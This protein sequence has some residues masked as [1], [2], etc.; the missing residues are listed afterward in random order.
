MAEYHEVRASFDRET[1]VVYQAYNDAIADAALQA[2]RFVAPFSLN[3]MT[4]VK[5][6]Y[7]WMMERSGW[8][9]KANQN[10]ILA[11]RISR[12]G[13]EKALSLATLTS[14]HPPVHRS[15]DRWRSEFEA[16]QVHVQ[17]DPE[18]S[19][20]G[21]KMEHRTI[22]VGIS[23][24]LIHEY[25][26]SWIQKIDDVTELTAK[27]YRLKLDGEYARAKRLL[28]VEKLYELPERI[29]GRLGM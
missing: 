8:G 20:R 27:I 5:P 4:W 13:W 18:R 19:I 3:R 16:A 23:R 1:I 22:Q 14:F 10:R 21:Q 7:L 25:V 6:S 9:T 12:A 17:W 26:E 11:I 29:R 2:G 15:I 24:H 28:P